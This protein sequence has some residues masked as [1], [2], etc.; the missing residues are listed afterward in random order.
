MHIVVV[1]LYHHD[2]VGFLPDSSDQSSIGQSQSIIYANL[3]W[4]IRAMSVPS[5]PLFVADFHE[6]CSHPQQL[7]DQLTLAAKCAY[8]GM[9]PRQVI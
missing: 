3:A 2:H 8:A 5:A 4:Y 9:P 1:H 7:R 6:S